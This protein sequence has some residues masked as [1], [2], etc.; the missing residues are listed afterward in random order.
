MLSRRLG[1]SAE[2]RY[3]IVLN[4]SHDLAAHSPLVCVGVG[5]KITF[6]ADGNGSLFKDMGLTQDL[7]AHGMGVRGKRIALVVDDLKVTYIGVETG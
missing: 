7:T 1:Q 5:D 3:P 4:L 2:S 6:L